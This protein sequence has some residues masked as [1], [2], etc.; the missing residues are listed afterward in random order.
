MEQNI[1]LNRNRNILGRR[2]IIGAFIAAHGA[3]HAM[4]LSSPRPEGGVGNFVTR[5]GDIPA[6]NSLGLDAAGAEVL[7]AAL[8]LIAAAGLLASALMYYRG[9]AAWRKVLLASSAVSLVTLLVFWNDWMVMGP[10]IDL[11]LVAL[12]YRSLSQNAEA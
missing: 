8:V 6:L 11:G 5:G 12:A 2:N 10:V 4:L 3:M 9:T 1:T 7:G